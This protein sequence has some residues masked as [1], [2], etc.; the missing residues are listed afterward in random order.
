MSTTRV[1]TKFFEGAVD[2]TIGGIMQASIGAGIMKLGGY[3][4]NIPLLQV[5]KPAVIGAAVCGSLYRAYH[6]N[7]PGQVPTSQELKEKLGI[8]ILLDVGVG[9][10]GLA[11]TQPSE[12]DLPIKQYA[13]TLAIGSAIFGS[14]LV[15]G[16]EMNEKAQES[17]GKQIL[18]K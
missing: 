6:H 8:N 14:L 16:L 2:G 18:A 9:L 10:L 4:Q 5:V 13:F 11:M 3:L 15:K 1:L 12:S 17:N 7:N